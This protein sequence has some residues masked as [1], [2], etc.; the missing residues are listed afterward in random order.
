MTEIACFADEKAGCLGEDGGLYDAEKA[1][2]VVCV[3]VKQLGEK[4]D[5][6][7]DCAALILHSILRP[8]SN[9]G[10]SAVPHLPDRQLLEAVFLNADGSWAAGSASDWGSSTGT[11][12]RLIRLIDVET[13]IRP[14]LAGVVI[15]VGGITESLVKQSWGAFL[16]HMQFSAADGG[17][18]A[19]RVCLAIEALLVENAGNDRVLIPLFKTLNLLL[20]SSSFDTVQPPDS[21]LP[22]RFVEVLPPDPRP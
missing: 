8:A 11:F 14:V 22:V 9:K 21:P 15:S 16:S 7:R 3:L 5:R 1:R 20:T 2:R 17:K 13:Y 10:Y 18:L 12:P 4:I 19:L 6:V